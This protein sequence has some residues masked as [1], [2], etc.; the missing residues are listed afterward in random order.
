MRS[1]L[2]R[3]VNKV[4]CKPRHI[5]TDNGPQFRSR[6]FKIWCKHKQIDLRYGAVGKYGSI[7]IIERSFRTLKSEWLR[8]IIIPLDMSSIR[9]K[10][11]TYIRWYNCFRPHQGLKGAIPVEI[12]NSKPQKSDTFKF[13][14]DDNLQLIVTFFESDRHLPIIKLK[15]AA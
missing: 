9:K 8:K 12:Y 10:L 13:N 7:A 15:R 1:L 3:S 6:T 5:I 11:T 2:G 4:H 14:A